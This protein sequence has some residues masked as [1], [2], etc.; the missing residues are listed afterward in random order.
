[1]GRT[2]LWPRSTEV[3]E[4]KELVEKVVPCQ[5]HLDGQKGILRDQEHRF[6]AQRLAKESADKLA[7]LEAKLENVTKQA[8]PLIS[9]HKEAW[10]SSIYL[11]S[12]IDLLKQHC[13]RKAL[14]SECLF[15]AM[16][17]PD[18]THQCQGSRWGH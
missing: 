2:N 5:A 6:V 4:L 10:I 17:A 8:A 3:L 14:T 18:S 1:M 13:E 15:E 11:R 12:V 9:E 16:F 7:D